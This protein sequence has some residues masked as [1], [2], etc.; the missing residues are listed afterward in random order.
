M[1]RPSPNYMLVKVSKED[2]GLVDIKDIED[3]TQSGELLE[4][5]SAVVTDAKVGDTVYWNAYAER[6]SRVGNYA[7]I[8]KDQI[9]AY[10]PKG[11]TK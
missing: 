6:N 2:S 9:T 10:E 5:G 3:T 8:F 11:A 7:L 4:I 1:L